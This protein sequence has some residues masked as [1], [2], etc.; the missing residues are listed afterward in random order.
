MWCCTVYTL[1]VVG[2]DD[3][4]NELKDKND[5]NDDDFDD[6]IAKSP[7][8]SSVHYHFSSC[9]QSVSHLD[10]ICGGFSTQKLHLFTFPVQCSFI[11]TMN[12][13]TAKLNSLA[14]PFQCFRTHIHQ[15]QFAVKMLRLITYKSVQAQQCF[16]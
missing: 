9:L 14:V 12:W 5:D 10:S 7:R 4:D 13:L 16:D 1:Q 3:G 2:N 15:F 11:Q 8:K 6:G